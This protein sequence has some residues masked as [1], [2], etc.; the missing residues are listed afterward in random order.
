MR[1]ILFIF[2]F[3]PFALKSQTVNTFRDSTW[4]KR[5][6]RFDS[7]LVF[8]KGA[9]VG[10]VW[11]SNAN[12]TG[13]WQTFSSAGVTQGALNDSISSVRG[14]IPDV[15]SY[16]TITNLKDSTALVGVDS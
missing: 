11:T 3:V 5:G 4:F 10:K 8:S 7:T 9:G 6:V 16:A 15:S 14:L 2:L 13:S 12:G 1:K